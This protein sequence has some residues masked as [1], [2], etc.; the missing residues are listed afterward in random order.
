MR[1][2]YDKFAH[3]EIQD[4]ETQ[5]EKANRCLSINSNDT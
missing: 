3:K 1:P 4:L 5:L 2:C